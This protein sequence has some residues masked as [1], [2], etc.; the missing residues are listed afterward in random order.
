MIYFRFISIFIFSGVFTSAFAQVREVYKPSQLFSVIS[1]E[2]QK[3]NRIILNHPDFYITVSGDILY[4]GRYSESYRVKPLADSWIE[5]PHTIANDLTKILEKRISQ[6][7]EM[8]DSLNRVGKITARGFFIATA[9]ELVKENGPRLSTL[10][11]H[12]S[13]AVFQNN[14]FSSGR[15]VK[16]EVN[17]EGIYKITKSDL[18]RFGFSGDENSFLLSVYSSLTDASLGTQPI[19]LWTKETE[20]AT[21]SET[22]EYYCRI[23]YWKGLSFNSSLKKWSH[24][25]DVY[26]NHQYVF[27]GFGTANGK[28]MTTIDNSSLTTSSLT[29]EARN[30]VWI[31]DEVD[32]L[33]KSGSRWFGRPMNENSSQTFRLK[34]TNYK[35]GA[36][37]NFSTRVI[38]RFPYNKTARFDLYEKNYSESMPFLQINPYGV[39]IAGTTG[40]YANEVLGTKQLNGMTDNELVVKYQFVTAAIATGWVDWIEADYPILL[41]QPK[42]N[43]S[44]F[45]TPAQNPNN[46]LV[47]VSGFSSSHLRVLN[48]DNE[49]EPQFVSSTINA[50]DVQFKW[51]YHPSKPNRFLV[52]DES[53]IP[54]NFGNYSTVNNFNFNAISTSTDY[55]IL[56][57]NDLLDQAQR[58]LNHRNQQGW[59]GVV[60][61]VNQIYTAY[62][63]GKQNIYGIRQF[64]K[65]VFLYTNQQLKNVLFFGD[66]SFDYKG[67][68]K[69]SPLKNVLPTFES[70][71]SLNQSNTYASDDFY[72]SLVTSMYDIG[73][74]RL[75]VTTIENAKIVV[76]KLINYDNN[77]EF[78][79]WRN[80]ITFVAD[81][82]KTSNGDD[83]DLHTANAETVAAIVPSY[84]T[85][86]KI[87]L[88]N[89]PTVISSDGRRKPEVTRDLIT[90]FNAGTIVVNYSGHGNS[91]VWTHERV[92][93]GESFLTQLSNKNKLPFVI[94]ATCDFGKFDDNESQS[95]AELFILKQDA[96]AIGLFTT[97]RL[98]YTSYNY[99]GGGGTYLTN[100]LALN[101]SLFEYLFQKTNAGKN[102][103]VGEIYRLSK[104][105]IGYTDENLK[106]F[107]L[108]ADPAMRLHFPRQASSFFKSNLS[109]YSS[110][111]TL[112]LTTLQL[113]QLSGKTFSVDNQPMNN[114]NGEILVRLKGEDQKIT[115]PEWASRPAGTFYMEGADIYRGLATVKNGNFDVRFFLPKDVVE[116]SRS[117]KFSG[118]YWNDVTD[119]YL[120]T[121]KTF[122]KYN[123]QITTYDQ[124]PPDIHL[125]VN[126]ST[127]QNGQTVSPQSVIIAMISDSSGI[128]TTG[129]GIGHQLMGIIDG[130]VNDFIDLS[131]YYI[132]SKDDFRK[133]MIAYPLHSLSAGQHTFSVKVWDS[134]N[135]G[136]TANISFL[137]SD[138]N[139]L[140]VDDV[141]PY[142]NPFS[143]KVNLY[144]THNLVN[145][146]LK[147][148]ANIFTV[149]GLL[150]RTIKNYLTDS[151]NHAKIEWDGLDQQGDHVANGIYLVSVTIED[152]KLGKK[153][154]KIAKVFYLK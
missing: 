72:S 26:D 14:P 28:R 128:N 30:L 87:Y 103:S 19:S 101:Y 83:Y 66:T 147:I 48:I 13:S 89:Y 146:E 22:Q 98:V 140:Q 112:S 64:L 108:L 91:K 132:A 150:I 31:E 104:N 17:E 40:N 145:G 142:P 47:K 92:L 136:S 114:F 63:G 77:S 105:R 123:N 50:G 144:F 10:I 106:K 75:P 44:F 43:V 120:T 130:H 67:L 126:D 65:D 84:L 12:S 88:I 1:G 24:L 41:D 96:G 38:A 82:G 110:Y 49:A 60:V 90:T 70:S 135:N 78:G 94:T 61:S 55:I 59:N 69:E 141:V 86:N 62:S 20:V 4:V 32:N 15:W 81:D 29:T 153:F 152:L 129:L 8:S 57:T 143:D 138:T 52:F 54:N 133:G 131:K 134:F 46:T 116:N 137:I 118:Y 122:F 33:L 73:V 35:I 127:F 149:N 121:P 27:I 124:T 11:S 80:T 16:V 125:F 79:D 113:N 58:L 99:Q 56:T 115:I 97:T 25:Q 85:T 76:D 7:F 21:I 18:R 95:S 139:E 3:E 109:A 151:S 2:T 111:D 23:P 39:D 37:I 9:F 36:P 93:E 42:N 107:A 117:A 71:E 154:S 45:L 5:V 6:P 148:K 53:V 34:L 68:I 119:G 51:S 102:Y 74:G 100:N